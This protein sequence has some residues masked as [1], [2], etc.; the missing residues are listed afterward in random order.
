MTSQ[1]SEVTWQNRFLLFAA[2]FQT[3]R[4][5]IAHFVLGALALASFAF[6]LLLYVATHQTQLRL[7]EDLLK[8]D[9][10][11][12]CI[13]S[14]ASEAE[15]ADLR[16]WC[17]SHDFVSAA[18]FK[19]YASYLSEIFESL[20][21]NPAALG[22]V[23]SDSVPSILDIRLKPHKASRAQMSRFMRDLR[24]RANVLEFYFKGDAPLALS[25]VAVKVEGF[26]LAIVILALLLTATTLFCGDIALLRAMR[27][28]I[29][30][31]KAAGASLKTVSRLFAAYTAIQWAI[32]LGLG[33]ILCVTL[34]PIEAGR[35]HGILVDLES[36]FAPQ[37]GVFSVVFVALLAAV[38]CLAPL[39]IAVRY[40]LSRLNVF[41]LQEDGL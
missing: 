8:C 4:V 12:I 40:R 23:P 27:D 26:L 34:F 28:E 29:G 30:V 1:P 31:M 32:A 15:L 39:L 11:T 14:D 38:V 7:V 6:V 33:Y 5:N 36:L 16:S 24:A 2:A 41:S 17:Q 3:I 25:E 13:S 22:S 9:H 37:L 18:E 35:L 19:P 21:L 10:L 20:D